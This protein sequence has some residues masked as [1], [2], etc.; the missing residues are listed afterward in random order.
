M[1]SYNATTYTISRN[2][3]LRNKKT[4]TNPNSQTLYVSYDVFFSVRQTHFASVVFMVF[5]SFTQS[6]NSSKSHF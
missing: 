4:A 6:Q 3:Y 2:I 5:L 1:S